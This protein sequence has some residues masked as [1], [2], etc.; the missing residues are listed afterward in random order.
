MRYSR[1]IPPTIQQS[2]IECI[3][4]YVL[5]AP[6]RL[7]K[8]GE[9]IFIDPLAM[10]RAT[11]IIRQAWCFSRLH[12]YASI[13]ADGLQFY[14]GYATGVGAMRGLL[15][16][17]YSQ[18]PFTSSTGEVLS[19]ITNQNSY[20]QS[21]YRGNGPV[22]VTKNMPILTGE[23]MAN[24]SIIDDEVAEAYCL[25]HE[26]INH[27]S[28][29]VKN[30]VQ[31]MLSIL[32]DEDEGLTAMPASEVMQKLDQ[33]YDKS[34]R[35]Y[36]PEGSKLTGFSAS[37]EGILDSSEAFW[38]NLLRTAKIPVW[39][40]SKEISNSSFSM[41]EK[42]D[43]ALR[44]WRQYCEDPYYQILRHLGLS[45][46][47]TIHP[48]EYRSPTHVATRADVIATSVQ[49]IETARRVA[50]SRMIDEMKMENGFYDEEANPHELLELA[51]ELK[52]GLAEEADARSDEMTKDDPNK[53]EAQ[54]KDDGL[55]K[56]GRSAV[57]GTKQDM[58]QAIS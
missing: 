5:A 43:Y 20:Y 21:G 3:P 52:G 25:Y 48:P 22:I 56:D 1:E 32:A 16:G 31:S 37:L 55:N 7:F 49:R 39:M 36:A 28:L 51:S 54:P 19:I 17:G 12:G 34:R 24:R 41:E 23:T 26:A 38:I 46:K 42:E 18:E 10:V 13:S 8:N 14:I 9:E 50:A 57:D 53:K 33:Q 40:L 4:D 11:N 35:M 6:P 58:T 44:H 29:R 47:V 27:M 2:L 45:K 30:S 15:G